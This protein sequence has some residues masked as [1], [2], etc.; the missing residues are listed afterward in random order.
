MQVD[1]DDRHQ[2]FAAFH[3]T[4]HKTIGGEGV[5]SKQRNYR[6]ISR[7]PDLTSKAYVFCRTDSIECCGLK[8]N[9]LGK[10]IKT[11]DDSDAAG[12]A[13][14]SAAANRSVGNAIRAQGFEHGTAG[15]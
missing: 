8:S 4:A 9:R 7:W 6:N 5:G 15:Q 14:R 11:V 10:L 2:A 3:A 1:E 13:A 12:G